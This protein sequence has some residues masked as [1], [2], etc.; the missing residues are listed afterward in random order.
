VVV[1]DAS[2]ARAPTGLRDSKL[3]SPSRREAL[4]PAIESWGAD[5]GLGEAS[6]G[7]VDRF[8]VN[9]ALRLAGW[10]AL[11]QLSS[12]PDLVLLDGGHD[13]LTRAGAIAEHEG[14]RPVGAPAG[15]VPSP[16]QP[17]ATPVAV[18]TRVR[19]DRTCASVAAASVLAKVARDA[20]MVGLAGA[21]PDY[22]WEENKGY[23]TSAHFD[24]LR[25]LGPTPHHRL[26][27]RLPVTDGEA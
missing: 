4:V 13:W 17:E 9:G 16:D 7:E 3:L 22:G 14:Y 21:Y 5:W 15:P 1:V 24:A 2:V 27:W 19:A 25:R 20:V 23:G 11:G 12:P 18:V 8:G 26:S 6:A 10:R